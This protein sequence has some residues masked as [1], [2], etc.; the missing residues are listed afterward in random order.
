MMITVIADAPY[1]LQDRRFAVPTLYVCNCQCAADYYYTIHV[2]HLISDTKYRKE[3]R[4]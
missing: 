1:I 2:F 3:V 4:L